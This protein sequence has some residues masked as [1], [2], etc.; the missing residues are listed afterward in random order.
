M[1]NEEAITEIERKAKVLTKS[2]IRISCFLNL[3]VLRCLE[4]NEDISK[5]NNSFI[6]Y[7]CTDLFGKNKNLKKKRRDMMNKIANM[8]PYKALEYRFTNLDNLIN[9]IYGN[10][11]MNVQNMLIST[12]EAR[13]KKYL[14]FII[15][16][17]VEKPNDKEKNEDIDFI[18]KKPT[19]SKNVVPSQKEP[20]EI[21]MQVIPVLIK[22]IQALSGMNKLTE[23]NIKANASRMLKFY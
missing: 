20:S 4:N 12:L 1:N 5:L 7:V 22:E 19:Y 15:A 21:L 2:S 23:T 9:Y 6:Q 14:R 8:D 13:L 11:E 16:E 3:F 10:L 17:T 18:I